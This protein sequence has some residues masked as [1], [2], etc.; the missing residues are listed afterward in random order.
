MNHEGGDKNMKMVGRPPS[1]IPSVASRRLARDG[2]TGSTRPIVIDHSY[3]W[4]K[5]L[6]VVLPHVLGGIVCICSMTV[7]WFTSGKRWRQRWQ[8]D[9]FRWHRWE[10]WWR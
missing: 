8:R 4:C 6:Q 10:W 7:W 9:G 1:L 5:I 3:G 2:M